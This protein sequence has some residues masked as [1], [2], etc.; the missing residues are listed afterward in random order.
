MMG[1]EGARAG[2][3]LNWAQGPACW[4]PWEDLVKLPWCLLMW[5][6]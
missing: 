2:G 1:R 6:A 3:T 5:E 4:E